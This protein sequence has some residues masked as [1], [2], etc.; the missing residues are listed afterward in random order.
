MQLKKII[1]STIFLLDKS[2][3][4]VLV[5]GDVDLRTIIGKE[6]IAI[7][8]LEFVFVKRPSKTNLEFLKCL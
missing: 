6:A 8:E 1:A 7:K 4:V 3:R 2:F 5:E